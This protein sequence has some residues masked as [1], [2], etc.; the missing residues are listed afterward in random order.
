MR[1]W[2]APVALRSSLRRR[3]A[4]PMGAVRSATQ[5]L[6]AMQKRMDA[7]LMAAG[8]AR[9]QN[10]AA[11]PS[12]GSRTSVSGPA[13]RRQS[14]TPGPATSA[15]APLAGDR[16]LFTSLV[17]LIQALPRTLSLVL[18][19]ICR[20]TGA[21]S[22][23]VQSK[24]KT[25]RPCFRARGASLFSARAVHVTAATQPTNGTCCQLQTIDDGVNLPCN[26]V[27]QGSTA[28]WPCRAPRRR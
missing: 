13:G 25:G 10:G 2:R 27:G 19:P 14:T 18:L 22:P 28:A 4:V 12:R 5:G 21:C 17:P 20:R 15:A 24:A 9:A 26:P 3:W 16:E 6:R 11:R 1:C 23:C 8:A 7:A